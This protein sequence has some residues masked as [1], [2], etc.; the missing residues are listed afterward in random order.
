[1]DTK[2]KIIIV[3]FVAIAFLYAG[4]FV[5]NYMNNSKKRETFVDDD[6]VEHYE[7]P[8]KQTTK[9]AATTASAESNYD[10]RVLILDDIEKLHVTD[11]EVKG[12]LME[13]LFSKAGLDKIGPMTST[14]RLA[15]IKSEYEKLKTGGT[16]PSATE[17]AA[18]KPQPAAQPSVSTPAA[19]P[20]PQAAPKAEFTNQDTSSEGKELVTKTREALNHLQYVQNGLQDIQKYAEGL[21]SSFEVKPL[22]PAA[23]SVAENYKEPRIP[24]AFIEGFENIRSYATIF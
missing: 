14:D 18:P 2:Y 8:P 4:H 22:P 21:K 19:D 9:P 7:E 16:A 23:P 15:Y 6:D 1:M 13:E 12:K 20:K 24:E 10:L 5:I 17:T 3:V 11:K